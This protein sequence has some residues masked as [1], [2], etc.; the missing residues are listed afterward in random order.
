MSLQSNI[1][2]DK[3]SGCFIFINKL[4][5]QSCVAFFQLKFKA[6][7]YLYAAGRLAQRHGLIGESFENIRQEML[8]LAT[9]GGVQR[10]AL[11]DSCVTWAEYSQLY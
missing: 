10:F 8:D 6:L 5:P 2:C 9:Q 7:R 3:L 11:Y 4:Y 1:N